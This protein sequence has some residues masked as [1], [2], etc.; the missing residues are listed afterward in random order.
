MH[1]F[2]VLSLCSLILCMF[3]GLEFY[4]AY[5]SSLLGDDMIDEQHFTYIGF[6]FFLIAVTF[7]SDCTYLVSLAAYISW[8]LAYQM[9]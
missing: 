9:I 1:I 3:S 6:C 5:D 2:L 7:C 8:R 4:C